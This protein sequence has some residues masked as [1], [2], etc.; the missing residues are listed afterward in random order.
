MDQT[1]SIK[2][3][4]KRLE[5]AE[6]RRARLDKNNEKARAK[7][8]TETEQKKDSI[9]CPW[10]RIKV[11]IPSKE[12]KRSIVRACGYKFFDFLKFSLLV[13]IL[14]ICS[15]KK[16]YNDVYLKCCYHTLEYEMGILMI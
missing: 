1:K 8:R 2:L 3:Q 5:S 4:K 12:I 6:E 15:H 16:Y 7:S 9:W 13:N 14:T 11:D 10:L